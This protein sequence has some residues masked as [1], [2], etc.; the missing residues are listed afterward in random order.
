MRAIAKA[1]LALLIL[2]LSAAAAYWMVNSRKPPETVVAEPPVLVIETLEIERKTHTPVIAAQGMVEPI[3]ETVLSAEVSGR[4]ISVAEHFEAGLDVKKGDV[5]VELDSSD[6]KAALAA[7][8]S[9]V[10]EARLDLANQEAAAEQARR[11]WQRLS[12]SDS[13]P[14]PLA[15]R[16]PQLEA[17]RARLNAALA[18]EQ[19]AGV[20]LERTRIRAPFDA[21]V[22]T[23]QAE[24]GMVLSP[25]MVV[26]ELFSVEGFR[27]RLPLRLSEAAM[28]P[29]AD[30]DPP[31]R[32]V[33]DQEGK[34][35][36]WSARLVRTEGEVDRS[37]RTLMHVAE[38]R[39]GRDGNDTPP[40]PG[41]FLRAEIAGRPLDS[42]ARVP[43]RALTAPDE[44]L[45]LTQDGVLQRGK[46]EVI[47]ADRNY[48]YLGQ[49][50]EQGDLVTLTTVESVIDGK[51]RA[52]RSEGAPPPS[53]L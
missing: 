27:V 3:R 23:R 22:R 20:N 37:S 5:L 8:A 41:L 46:V 33:W 44:V 53:E 14:P 19:L 10:A 18:E 42:V 30:S 7:A 12:G 16:Q 50:V 25:G 39:A 35:Q 49:G 48:A 11:D 15:A 34:T 29:P 52:T 38:W 45:F 28:L 32:L 26:G 43:R 2:A 36:E 4:A 6:Y 51:T 31:V 24:V 9:R 21:R 47:F 1:I 40:P 13:A 17:A